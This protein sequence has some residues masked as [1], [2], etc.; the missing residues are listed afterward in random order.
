MIDI[1]MCW[2]SD[3]EVS[4]FAE[5]LGITETKVRHL[6]ATHDAYVKALGEIEDPLQGVT[7]LLTTATAM[8][9]HSGIPAEQFIKAFQSVVEILSAPDL[10]MKEGTEA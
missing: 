7:I 9:K 1:G 8:A 10:L 3:K 5:N 2:M 4:Y 6:M